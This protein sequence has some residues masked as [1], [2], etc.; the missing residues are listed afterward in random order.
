MFVVAAALAKVANSAIRDE[1]DVLGRGRIVS[2]YQIGEMAKVATIFLFVT[3]PWLSGVR[4]FSARNSG[5]WLQGQ[6]ASLPVA[7]GQ[8]A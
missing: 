4:E 5:F 3:P 7:T 1:S 6:M 8:P 2:L